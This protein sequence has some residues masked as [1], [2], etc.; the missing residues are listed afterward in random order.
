MRHHLLRTLIGLPVKTGLAGCLFRTSSMCKYLCNYTRPTSSFLISSRSNSSP[1][2]VV[3]LQYSSFRSAGTRSSHTVARFIRRTSITVMKV[4]ASSLLVGAAAAAAVSPQQYVLQQSESI[5]HELKDAVSKP[6]HHL[7]DSFD[8][9][10]AETRAI[11][12]EVSMMFP[13]AMN[14]ANFISA[15]KKHT[16]RPDSQWDHIVKGADVQSIWV[17]GKNGQKE[18]EVD[19]RLED[20]SMRV[21]KVDPSSL[22]VDPGVKQYSGYL[23]D[24][25]EDKHLFYCK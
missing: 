21:K 8:S 7:Q 17:E 18:R 15:P 1:I 24:D 10:S 25:K 2:L 9:M 5:A 16:R 6:F 12:D 11:W 14:Q 20:Y 4:L 19:G 3:Q 13:E 22:G 23:D